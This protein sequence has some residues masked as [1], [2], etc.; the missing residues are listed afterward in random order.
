MALATRCPGCTTVFR[1]SSAQA[2]AKG[3]MVRCGVCRNVFN[4]L[5]ALVR[6]E[7][8]DVIEEVVIVPEGAPA[9]AIATAIEPEVEPRAWADERAAAAAL[10][11]DAGLNEDT[12]H[13]VEPAFLGERPVISEWWLPEPTSSG[14]TAHRTVERLDI[15]E[16]PL[17]LR[18]G[19]LAPD[20]VALDGTNPLFMRPATESARTS[21]ALRWTMSVLSLVAALAL[22]AQLAYF[23]RDELAARWSPARPWLT[24]ACNRLGCVV[25]YPAHAESV[26]IESASVQTTGA[27]S[28]VYV[29]SALLRNR[30]AIDLRYPHLQLVLTD[31]Q[32]RPI[33]RRD[34]RPED[35]LAAGRSPQAGFP[36]GTELSVRVA[37]ELND[38]RF[39]G[40]RINQ[41]YP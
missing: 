27:G 12:G 15:A 8:L 7:E 21:S 34:L 23:W 2:A 17:S 6:V 28:N 32:D 33:L 31:L 11:T 38:L 30:D 37:F 20:A 18:G 35:Y 13:R 40:Y 29:M 4:S 10:A 16:R 19:D 1:I 5:D 3:G 22:L 24:A 9:S 39:A 36:A 41:F 14:T 25:A 26:T